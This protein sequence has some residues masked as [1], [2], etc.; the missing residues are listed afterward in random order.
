LM[1]GTTFNEASALQEAMNGRPER[2]RNL[3]IRFRGKAIPDLSRDEAIE[4][5][6][7]AI[8]QIKRMGGP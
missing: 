5:L 1:F 3:D 2:N 7:Q 6:H 8:E 4:A